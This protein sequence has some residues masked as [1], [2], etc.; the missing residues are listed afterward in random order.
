MDRFSVSL[1][2]LA[3]LAV[4]CALSCFTAASASAAPLLWAVNSNTESVSTLEASSGHEV[5]LPIHTGKDPD[6]IA[7]T[8][9]GRYAWVVSN[10]SQNVTV[11]ETATRIPVATIKLPANGE[12]VAISPDGKTAYVTV[13]GGSEIYEFSTA[14]FAEIGTITAGPEAFAFAI[15]PNGE[16]AY[17]G[18]EPDEVQEIN[19]RNGSPAAQPLKVGGSVRAIAY[20]PD[21]STVYVGAGAELA[22]I[23]GGAVVKEIPLG[24]EARGIAVSPDGSRVYVTAKNP[25]KNVTVINAATNETVGTPIP[26][27]GEPEE[28]ALTAN[29]RTA[30]VGTGEGITPINLTAPQPKTPV[31]R[32]GQGAFDLVVAPDQPPVAAFTPPEATVGVPATFSGAPS[33]DPDGSIAKFQWFTNFGISPT[34]LTFTHTFNV[35]D[36]YFTNLT[37]T[38]DEGCSTSQ[39]FTGRTASCNGSNVATVSHP[40]TVRTAPVVC[41]AKFGIGGVTHNRKNGT[42]RLRLKFRSTGF[43]LVFGKKIHAVTRKVRRPGTTVVTLHARVELNKR[44]KKT[45]RASVRYRVTFTPSAGCGSK[46]V[47]RSVALLRAPRKKHHR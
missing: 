16:L 22:V 23:K 24:S 11:I 3:A 40:V 39:V 28:I 20:S 35:V 32:T 12:R 34:G 13:E 9:D 8:P 29:G 10:Q 14:T 18:I 5:G 43:F 21:G 44:L 26:L 6:S 36:N 19:L 7:I 38:D 41:S 47:H 25:T 2:G 46:T 17:A 1:R 15:D 30:Y 37:V 33:S 45:L 31:A 27:T 42:V 4:V